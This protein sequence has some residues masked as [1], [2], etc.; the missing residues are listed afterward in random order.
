MREKNKQ[1]VLKLPPNE[2]LI[3][4]AY[5]AQHFDQDLKNHN[6]GTMHSVIGEMMVDIA[7]AI[8]ECFDFPDEKAGDE[9]LRQALKE[10]AKR[11]W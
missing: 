1:F 6:T 10:L 2:A 3:L 4:Q 8:G 7:A 9:Q 11:Y 5:L